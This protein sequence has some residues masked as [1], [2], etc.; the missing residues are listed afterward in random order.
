MKR[1]KN[2]TSLTKLYNMFITSD[3]YFDPLLQ[4]KVV[5]VDTSTLKSE[6][7]WSECFNEV[8]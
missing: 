8:G 4:K 6:F 2:T 5:F 1:N 3:K 7:M